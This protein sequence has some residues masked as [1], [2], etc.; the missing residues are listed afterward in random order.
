ML[1]LIHAQTVQG[2]L[3]VD[4][5]DDGLPN[6]NVHRLGSTAD[7]NA[8]ERDGYANSAKQKAYIPRVKAGAPATPGYVDLKETDRVTLS[9]DRGKISKMSQAGLITVV[10]LVAS[11]LAEPAIT[12]ATIDTPGAGDLTIVGTGFL[13]VAPEIS[14]V[15]L[16]GSGVGDLTLTRTQITS[17]GGT[18]TNTSIVILAASA[19]SLAAGDVVTVMADAQTS[20]PE[21]VV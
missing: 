13:S 9:A 11:D 2:A 21:T 12:T 4:D 17:G 16:T 20:D 18:F 10:S 5:I 6:K 15:H 3:L 19:P 14:S 7:P 8:Y 1:R